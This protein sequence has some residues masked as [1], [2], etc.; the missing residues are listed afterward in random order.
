MNRLKEIFERLHKEFFKNA[1]FIITFVVILLLG[2]FFVP[3]IFAQL[4]PIRNIEFFSDKV[5]YEKKEP[6]AWKVEKSAKWISKGIAEITFDVKSNLKTKYVYYDILF[7]LDTSDSMEGKKISK[8]KEDTR[9]LIDELFSKEGNR[10]GFITFDTSSSILSNFINDR[11]TAKD[12]LNSIG[13]NGNTNYYDALVNVDSVLANYTPEDNRGC[14]VLFLTD[15]YPNVKIP[16]EAGQYAYLKEKYP[17]L[18]I[19]G[20]QY[21]MGSEILEPIKKVTDNQFAADMSTLHNTLF[22]AAFVPIS[23]DEFKI[24]DYINSEYFYIDDASDIKV[25]YGNVNFDKKKQNFVWSFNNLTT[26]RNVKLTAEVK[27]KDEFLEVDGVYPTNKNE[28]ISSTISNEVKEISSK[29]TPTLKNMYSVTYDVNAPNGCKIEDV[30]AEKKYFVF[31]TVAINDKTLKCE[32]Y[33]FKGW[34]IVTEGVEKVNDDFFT[35]PEEDVLIRASWSGLSLEKSMQ[36]TIQEKLTLYKQVELDATNEVGAYKYSDNNFSFTNDYPIYYYDNATANNNV[37]FGGFCWQM[38]RTTDTGGVKMVYN[39]LPDNDGKCNNSGAAAALKNT[40]SFNDNSDSVSDVGYMFNTRYPYKTERLIDSYT[41]LSSRNMG[42]SENY[43]YFYSDTYEYSHSSYILKN[44]EKVVWTGNN[45]DLVGKYTCGTATSSSNCYNLL[46]I[47]KADAEKIYY[48]ELR[49]GNGLNDEGFGLT[50]TFS[51]TVTSNGDGTYTL[52]SP[53]VINKADW[54]DNNVA[55]LNYYTCGNNDIVCSSLKQVISTNSS[56]ATF[57]YGTKK[58][59]NSF[60]W[61]GNNYKLIDTVDI[62]DWDKEYNNINNYHYTCFNEN[63]ICDKISYIYS[64]N[65][66]QAYYIELSGGKNVN[67]ALNEMLYNDDVNKY[68]SVIKSVLDSWYEENLASYT[69]YLEDTVWCNDRKAK[70]LS[71]SGWN[72]NG[73]KMS[74]D[75]EFGGDYDFSF[76]CSKLNDR[77]TINTGVGNGALTYPI[78]IL[79]LAESFTGKNSTFFGKADLWTLS[80]A[81]F[82]QHSRAANHLMTSYVSF[83][84]R[85]PSPV[86]NSKY[87]RPSISLRAGVGYSSGDG[88]TDNPYVIDLDHSMHRIYVDS[89][90]VNPENNIS[91]GG[92]KVNLLPVN[93][94]FSIISFKLNGKLIEGNSFVMP[95]KDAYITDVILRKAIIVESEHYPYSDDLYVEKEKTFEGASSLTIELLCETESLYSDYVNLFD[96]SGHSYG[97]FGGKS[98]KKTIVIPGDY[99]RFLFNT[100]YSYGNYY[101]YR[102]KIFPNYD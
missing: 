7:V 38:V 92:Q 52:T 80:P 60:M 79:T 59:G 39:G 71:N 24:D 12:V 63:G 64:T 89:F 18:I 47:V 31:D 36:G 102:A 20:V 16:N 22:E 49:N 23:Y 94:E 25:D 44:P 91:F 46:Y 11:D 65:S 101:G 81:D 8:V 17:F 61:D 9:E 62:L 90:E 86:G 87:V 42:V 93:D 83:S 98:V 66:Y 41:I 28:I 29:K 78:G 48:I 35:M 99:V 3:R 26:S 72:P 57:A 34:K 75:L 27:L 88:S 50:I 82:A 95:Q 15:G 32:G 14:I 1:I 68:D 40:S 45:A 21:E 30:P 77:F 33:H 85:Y 70:N 10:V 13:V 74:T 84:V 6:G 37:L 73:G 53:T 43:D 67:D 55:Y 56:S 100:N 2:V 58:Y 54:N 76:S 4:Q 69:D 96:K 51:D 5:N 97:S 19:N